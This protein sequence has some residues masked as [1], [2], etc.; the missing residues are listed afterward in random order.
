MLVIFSFTLA[1]ANEVKLPP[2]TED[3]L[4]NGLVVVAIENHE[5]PTITL[6]MVIRAGSAYD[7]SR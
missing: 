7:P 1:G 3:T 6:K 4:S 2:I 5:L